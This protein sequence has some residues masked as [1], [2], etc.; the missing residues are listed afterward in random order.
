MIQLFFDLLAIC[1]VARILL[2]LTGHN[3]GR[4]YQ[5]VFTLSEMIL[6]PLRKILPKTSVDWSPFA[7]LIILEML[8]K[9][10]NPL[11]FF[12]VNGQYGRI[13]PLFYGVFL[14]MLSSIA[15]ILIII[16]IVKIVNDVVKG[17]NYTLTRVLDA[18]TEPM[19]VRVK[20]KLS[21]RHRRFAVWIILAL[22]IATEVFLKY[23]MNRMDL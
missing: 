14:S 16:F 23:E 4:I 15:V 1:I 20:T 9:L 19:I 18:M 3:F 8:G 12:I 11:V 5:F 13:L 22:L 2:S 10:I 6:G 17:D 21:F 7:A